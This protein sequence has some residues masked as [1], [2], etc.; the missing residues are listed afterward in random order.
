MRMHSF[1][2]GYLIEQHFSGWYSA[3]VMGVGTLKADSP[4]GIKQ[5][6]SDAEKPTA[7]PTPK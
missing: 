6:I 5:M 4:E 2:K 1:Y 7:N 3:F